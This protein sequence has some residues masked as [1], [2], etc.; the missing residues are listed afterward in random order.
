MRQIANMRQINPKLK[1]GG[2]LPTMW[3]RSENIQRAEETLRASG[4]PVYPHIRRTN[5]VD[6]MTFDQ[7][8][9][10]VSSPKSAAGR[11]LPHICSCAH[12]GGA[13]NG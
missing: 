3:Y 7:Q 13:V 4:L 5:K 8:P 2:L 11:G 10:L 1:L 12:G 9:L 6:D